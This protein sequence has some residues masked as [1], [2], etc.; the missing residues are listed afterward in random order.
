MCQP[1]KLRTDLADLGA[2][3]HRSRQSCSRRTYRSSESLECASSLAIAK[4]WHRPHRSTQVCTLDGLDQLRGFHRFC[5]RHVVGGTP[6]R[7]CP[8]ST[9]TIWDRSAF[10]NWRLR[11]RGRK[12]DIRQRFGP[13]ER[14][15]G[16]S[17]SPVVCSMYRSRSEPSKFSLHGSSS[18][19]FPPPR[20]PK[21]LARL[22]AW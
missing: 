18:T 15:A 19:H 20:N 7:P 2:E 14:N 10:G 8:I 4:Q 5:R 3:T 12:A 11:E 21:D 9:A 1:V 22:Y 17:F 16:D 13:A 6:G